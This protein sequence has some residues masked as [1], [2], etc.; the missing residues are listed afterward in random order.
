MSE[1]RPDVYNPTLRHYIAVLPLFLLTRLLQ[2]TVRLE[3]AAG[4]VAKMSSPERL[5][6]VAWHSRI[7]FLAMCKYW[8][9][10]GIPMS[11]LV[12]A[13]R[14]GAYLCAF[15]RL[16]KIGAVRGSHKRRGAAAV[17]E[18]VDTLR[19]GG[20]VFITPDGPVGPKN[21][22]KAGFALVAK[23]SG[24][25]VLALKIT[26][27]S[28]WRI[29][30]TWDKFILQD[31]RRPRTRRGGA[32]HRARKTGRKLSKLRQHRLMFAQKMRGDFRAPHLF[33]RYSK[34][35]C[36]T[37]CPLRFVSQRSRRAFPSSKESS[38][39]PRNGREQAACALRT[40]RPC[41]APRAMQKRACRL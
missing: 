24:A 13:S 7:F 3:A 21:R 30:K 16:S 4:D 26:P 10:D 39:C 27:K 25:R 15:F 9:R 40:C 8:Y 29:G 12:S 20:D 5:V 23:E 31:L 33:C 36:R 14:D 41:R 6:G 18:L 28:Y 22:A 2:S 37:F 11:G 35:I 32:K 17:K 19:G 1:K 38:K 34:T